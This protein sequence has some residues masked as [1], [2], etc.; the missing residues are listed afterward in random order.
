MTS[1]AQKIAIRNAIAARAANP[2]AKSAPGLC[3]KL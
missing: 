2:E 1:I 3:C